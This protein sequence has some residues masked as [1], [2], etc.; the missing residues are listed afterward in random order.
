[1]R[2]CGVSETCTSGGRDEISVTQNAR[3]RI[4]WRDNVFAV[5]VAIGGHLGDSRVRVRVVAGDI[6]YFGLFQGS[7]RAGVGFANGCR[8]VSRSN[9]AFLRCR[10]GRIYRN[11]FLGGQAPP[12]IYC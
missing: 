9:A 3:S 12:K 8:F 10:D 4:S 7:Y 1:M 5:S 11:D 6:C 2:D